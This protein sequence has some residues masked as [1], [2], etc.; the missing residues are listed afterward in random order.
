MKIDQI[1]YDSKYFYVSLV[2]CYE[3][4][5]GYYYDMIRQHTLS[6]YYKRVTTTL[7]VFAAHFLPLT[8]YLFIIIIIIIIIIVILPTRSYRLYPIIIPAVDNRYLF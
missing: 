3:Y 5:D 1:V 4:I 6:A 7:P 8:L 2:A